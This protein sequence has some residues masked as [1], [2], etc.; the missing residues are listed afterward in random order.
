MFVLILHRHRRRDHFGQ[1]FG[2]GHGLNAVALN[3]GARNAL[4]KTFFAKGFDH[5]CNIRFVSGLQ[6]FGSRLAAR[7]VHTH[8]QRTITH[9]GETAFSIIK[10]W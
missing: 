7:R 5:P 1:L 8:I 4:A 10:L 9:K 6:P 3:D 2:T